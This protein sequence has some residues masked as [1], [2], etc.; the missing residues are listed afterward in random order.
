MNKEKYEVRYKNIERQN[1]LAVEP[2]PGSYFWGEVGNAFEIWD[3]EGN[4][5]IC[6]NA[7]IAFDSWETCMSIDLQHTAKSCTVKTYSTPSASIST[8]E[9]L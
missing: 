2:D 5:L 7:S 3:V 9:Q 4:T 8:V 1:S 6:L